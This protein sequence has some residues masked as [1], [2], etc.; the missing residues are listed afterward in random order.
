MGLEVLRLRHL[1]NERAFCLSVRGFV[2]PPI[3]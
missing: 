3:C 2:S 1:A